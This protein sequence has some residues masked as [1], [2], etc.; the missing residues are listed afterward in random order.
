MIGVDTNILARLFV[1]DDDRQR[2]LAN[3]FFADRTPSDPAFVSLVVIAE[4][5]WLLRRTY[6]YPHQAILEAVMALLDSADFAV[7]ARDIVLAAVDT[8]GAH[9][10]GLADVLIAEIASRAGCAAT[11]TFDKTAA[12]RIPGMELLA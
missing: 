8:A 6:D 3:R 9:R 10:F 1:D 12:K 4:L 7:E 5:A 11:M 2:E